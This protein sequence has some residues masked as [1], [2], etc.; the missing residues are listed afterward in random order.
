[1][2]LPMNWIKVPGYRHVLPPE[3]TS[4]DLDFARYDKIHEYYL[5]V[6]LL[7]LI[8]SQTLPNDLKIDV[9]ESIPADVCRTLH[10]AVKLGAMDTG[11]VDEYFTISEE[12]SVRMHGFPRDFLKQQRRL[13]SL[14]NNPP[15]PDVESTTRSQPTKKSSGFHFLQL[16]RAIRDRIYRLLMVRRS[17]IQIGDFD[18]GVQPT[19]LFRRTEYE[20]YDTKTRRPRRTTYTVRMVQFEFPINFNVMLLNKTIC[21][22]AQ[23]IFYGENTFAF[24]GSAESALSFFHDRASRLDTLRKVSMRFS[25]STKSFKGCYNAT[26]PIPLPSMTSAPA[27]RRIFNLFVHTSIGLEDFHLILDDSF[28][29]QLPEIKGVEAIFNKPGLCE[30]V[31]RVANDR[32]FLQ[33]VARL[34]GVNIRLTINGEGGKRER[35][36]FRR[37][38]E[39]R[40]QQDGFKRP[41]LAEDE[42]PECTCRKKLLFECCIWDKQGK[43]RRG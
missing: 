31:Y 30:P 26:C 8:R 14:I 2:P 7:W 3:L 10:H 29:L 22:E 1:M 35:A 36:L 33:H 32:N 43:M 21:K 13:Q 28:W 39:Q 24:L 5:F 6:K 17:D 40:L 18:F 19:G 34:G 12:V 41:Y 11:W 37:E 15:N 27:W 25:C 20:L 4:E 23:K 38:L 16:S 9:K 42:K